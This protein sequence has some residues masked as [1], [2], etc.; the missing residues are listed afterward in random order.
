MPPTPVAERTTGPTCPGC[1]SQQ[2]RVRQT[3]TEQMGAHIALRRRRRCEVC[4]RTWHTYEIPEEVA[5]PLLAR[6]PGELRRA[7]QTI[8]QIRRLVAAFD[9]REAQ[10]GSEQ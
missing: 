3:M 10:D 1:G 4:G 8:H 2:S 6:A 7:L 9:R 5:A